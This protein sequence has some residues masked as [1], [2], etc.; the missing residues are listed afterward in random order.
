MTTRGGRS[1]ITMLPAVVQQLQQRRI[2]RKPA[3]TFYL[4]QIPFTIQPF[5]IA[6]VLP[7][8]T[9]ENLM[10]QARVVTDPIQ[11]PIIGWWCEY[12]FF[13]VKLRDLDDRDTFTSMM[14]DPDTTTTALKETDDTVSQYYNPGVNNELNFVEKCLKRV[15]EE[16]FRNQDE[17]WNNV[18]INGLPVCSVIGDTWLD[19]FINDDSFQT[20]IEPTIDTSGASVGITTIEAAMRQWQLLQLD[21]MTDFTFEDYLRTYGVHVANEEPHRPELI[22]FIRQ[23]QYP[24]NTINQTTGAPTSAV[25]WAVAERAD[26]KR[27]FPEPGFIFGVSCIRAKTYFS[28]QSGAIANYLDTAQNWLPAV[29]SDDP[30]TSLV[31]YTAGAGPL[32]SNTDDYWFDI[33]DLFL[34][35]DQYLNEAP[36]TAGKNALALPTAGGVWRYPTNQAMLDGLFVSANA[37]IKQDGIVTLNIRGR[38]RE[39]S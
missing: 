34:H 21:N 19:S 36:A 16:Y 24:S 18:T 22:R 30:N 35:G 1:Q 11:N 10:L 8:E 5:V 6:P 39:T 28:N 3:H 17:T 33:K 31:Q 4:K 38:L 27:F 2:A 29:L 26:K 32:K 23:W 13:Y 9:L 14:I 20:A 12:F 37:T 15:T 7:G 25:S